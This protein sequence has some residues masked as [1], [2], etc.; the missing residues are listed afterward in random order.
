MEGRKF[1]QEL[2]DWIRH[3]EYVKDA[4][5]FIG[6]WERWASADFAMFLNHYRKKQVGTETYSYDGLTERCDVLTQR[7]TEN[8]TREWREVIEMKFWTIE[9]GT[10]MLKAFLKLVVADIKKMRERKLTQWIRQKEAVLTVLELLQGELFHNDNDDIGYDGQK[11]T[12]RYTDS[13]GKKVA[14]EVTPF[15][16]SKGYTLFLWSEHRDPDP[17]MIEEEGT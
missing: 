17:D 6:G 10:M 7:D 5:T 13:A 12:L 4:P 3:S 1:L 8:P 2:K 11:C 9:D 14:V 15:D 16:A